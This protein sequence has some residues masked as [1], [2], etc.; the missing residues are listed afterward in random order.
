MDSSSADQPTR[1]WIGRGRG[2]LGLSVQ[3][4]SQKETRP[5]QQ[6]RL[7]SALAESQNSRP[8][9]PCKTSTWNQRQAI[10]PPANQHP[11]PDRRELVSSSDDV[12]S[13]DNN[14]TAARSLQNRIVGDNKSKTKRL[15]AKYSYKANQ[16]SPL[17]F[18]ELDIKQGQRLTLVER[19]PTNEHW[20]KV[21]DETGAVGYA[22][23][24][25][26]KIEETRPSVLPWLADTDGQSEVP[27][28]KP[29]LKPYVSAYNKQ[30][31]S[32]QSKVSE[33]DYY[34]GVCDKKLNGP[35]PYGAHMV[36][37]AHKEEVE[38]ARERGE[39]V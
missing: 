7:N 10:R 5:G 8:S 3:Q 11:T 16:N 27:S 14:G 38:I 17:G 21:R 28:E 30:A 39:D 18:S 20:W 34:C 9:D 36:S 24:S 32:E 33:N 35:K 2:V 26:M 37:K 13:Q 15:L 6:G 12:R 25:Y 19:H 22:P 23:A 1:R 31:K 4:I 29:V